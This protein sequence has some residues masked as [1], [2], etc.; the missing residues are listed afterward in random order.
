LFF[1]SGAQARS[2]LVSPLFVGAADGLLGQ[3]NA[4]SRTSTR[5]DWHFSKQIAEQWNFPFQ[6][7]ELSHLE[8]SIFDSTLMFS[9]SAFNREIQDVFF[10]RG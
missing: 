1:S 9:M 8:N 6:V 5:A 3:R 7:Q 2:S 10:A 4:N